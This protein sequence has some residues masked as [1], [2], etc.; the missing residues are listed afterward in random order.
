MVDLATS[1][2]SLIRRW[3]ERVTGVADTTHRIGEGV[4]ETGLAIRQV[5][6]GVVTGGILGAIDA[7]KGLDIR[8]GKRVIPADAVLAVAGLLGSVASVATGH[9]EVA[10]DFR[11]IGS[12]AGT[13]WAFRKARD[14]V[15]AKSMT[16]KITPPAT[17]TPAVHGETDIGADPVANAVKSL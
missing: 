9:T 17:A 4:H 1:K 7:K 3:Y 5:G 2:P 16:P 8:S 15:R 6:E 13:V 11:N 12:S 14:L 10:H